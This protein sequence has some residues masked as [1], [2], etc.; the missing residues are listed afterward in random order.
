MIGTE[1]QDSLLPWLKDKALPLWASNGWDD[2]THSFVERL[3][4][5]GEP[6]LDAPRRAM[7]Q[8]RQ[9]YSYSVAHRS[10]WFGD[11]AELVARAG[12]S[13][14]ERY[15]E[16]D[17]ARGWVFSVGRDGAV[18]DS[19]RD[20]YTHAFILLGLAKAFEATR[21]Y[22]YIALADATLSFL[23]RE[24]SSEHGGYVESLPAG[25]SPRRQNS[26]MH[27]FEAL[28]SLFD[29]TR[30]S[31]YLERAEAM[32]DLFFR[33]LVQAESS[34]V[35]E[36]FDADWGPLEGPNFPFEPGH[37]FEWIWL[38]EQNDELRHVDQTA[39]VARLWET[40]LRA[41]VGVDGRIFARATVGG[42]VDRSTRLWFYA[43]AAKAA[44]VMRSKYER[45][46]GPITS[47]FFAAMRARFL[48]PAISGSWIDEFDAHGAPKMNFA[49]ASSLYHLCCAIR[50]AEAQYC[51]C[52]LR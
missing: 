22:A 5:R 39:T 20:L 48:E 6:L 27:L 29:A 36:F 28:L 37:H 2:R 38:L 19:R 16:A 26:H 14:I 32:R 31:V 33:R 17:G 30:N 24:M 8:A 10:G 42:A 35:V 7:V 47:D 40:A 49:P 43:E 9:I 45:F 46:D 44:H 21:D 51:S 41:G 4:L 15:Y 52:F 3:S 1:K 23:D 12:T 25:D 34:V 18:L 50:A 11:G 13:M